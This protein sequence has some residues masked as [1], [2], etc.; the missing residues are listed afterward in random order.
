LIAQ[1]QWP[2]WGGERIATFLKRQRDVY[3][4]I[5]D[6]SVRLL[7]HGYTPNE[8]AESLQMPASLANVWSTRGYYGTLSH[9]ANEFY[10]RY[11]C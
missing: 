7:N 10:K 1:H 2:T 3:K 6:Q 11:I 4:F 5:H 8:I 9:N